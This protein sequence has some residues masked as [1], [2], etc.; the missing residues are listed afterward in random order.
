[1]NTTGDQVAQTSADGWRDW[2]RRFVIASLAASFAFA[3]VLLSSGRE[4]LRGAVAD[5]PGITLDESFNIETGIY[6]VRSLN[7]YGLAF[8]HPRTIKEVWG[9]REYNPDHPPLGRWALGLVHDWNA[10]PNRPVIQDAAA[11]PASAVAFAITV[12]LVAWYAAKWFGASAG[13]IA[14]LALLFMPRQFGHAH[15]ASLETLI[16]LTYSWCVLWVADQ[17]RFSS[18]GPQPKQLPRQRIAIVGGILW[19]LA[20]LTKIQA[21]FIAPA[22]GL[23]AIW[24][25]GPRVLTRLAVF[26]VVG[27]VVFFA[28]WPWLWLDPLGHLKEFF[29][30][31]T[32][33]PTLYCFYWGERWADRDV[34]WHYPW[35]MFAVVVPLGL[36]LLGLLGVVSRWNDSPAESDHVRGCRDARL[37]LVLLAMLV[38]LAVFSVPGIRVY[39]GERLFG[40]VFPLWAVVMGR[41]GALLWRYAIHR[42]PVPTGGLVVAAL[43]A[44]QGWGILAYHP[45][46]LSF[47]S[48]A[49]GGLSG[50]D[51]LGFERTYWADSLTDSFQRRIVEAVPRGSTIDVAPVL[52]PFYLSHLL[53]QS[54]ILTAAE[55]QLAAYDD[56]Q[57]G[58]S[59]Y[60]LMFHR[61]ADPWGSLL[62]PPEGTET[63]AEMK[64]GDVPL[65]T[66]YRLP[67]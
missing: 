18:D 2:G 34:P 63:L 9:A 10:D 59:R 29:A 42:L 7:A 36:Q 32:E 31:T 19:G 46:Q 62:P 15:L 37:Q 43:I 66:V 8:L 28:G 41:G 64:R 27:F 25:F 56:K 44:V 65:A 3:A 17:W 54:P 51:R 20:L 23:W 4:V 26:G 24:R 58:R 47:Y 60:V 1:M 6:L 35:V 13:T 12:F 52:H 40:V 61:K 16:A 30:R 39:D 33:R 5:G 57:P 53:E 45:C 38:P 49:V 22:V 67:K 11:R 14:G 48:L 55:I 50:A 21:V